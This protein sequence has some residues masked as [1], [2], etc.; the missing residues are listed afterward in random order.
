MPGSN[1]SDSELMPSWGKNEAGIYKDGVIS[2]EREPPTL[3]SKGEEVRLWENL[4]VI[5]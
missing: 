1:A 2:S 3:L 4:I 5:L